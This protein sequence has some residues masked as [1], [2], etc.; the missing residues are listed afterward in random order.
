MCFVVVVCG[1]GS[2]SGSVIEMDVLK[3]YVN[4]TLSMNCYISS[5]HVNEIFKALSALCECTA[6]C[7]A[8]HFLNDTNSAAQCCRGRGSKILKIL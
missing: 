4:K 1:C 3:S 2:A 8:G 6:T 7:A 5:L